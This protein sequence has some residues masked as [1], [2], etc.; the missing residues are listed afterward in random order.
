MP[1]IDNR[2]EKLKGKVKVSKIRTNSGNGITY[3]EYDDKGRFIHSKDPD[4]FEKWQEYHQEQ[5]GG[6][7]HSTLKSSNGDVIYYEY[8]ND[9]N[10]GYKEFPN[11]DRTI[12]SYAGNGK[13]CYEKTLFYNG[14]ESE[15][16]FYEYNDK[17]DCIRSGDLETEYDYD[18]KG[19]CVHSKDSEGRENWYKYDEKGNC[20]YKKFNDGGWYKGDPDELEQWFE[21]DDKGNL[22]RERDNSGVDMQ[23]EYD[24]NGNITHYKDNRGNEEWQEL[25]YYPEVI[26]QYGL[27]D[28]RTDDLDEDKDGKFYMNTATGSVDTYQG[29]YYEGRNGELKNAVDEGK[30]VEVEKD[31]DGNWVEVEDYWK[32]KEKEK[33]ADKISDVLNDMEGKKSSVSKVKNRSCGMEM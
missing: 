18:G 32:Q 26:K 20:V 13:V 25:E 7:I 29:W 31:A 33:I 6:H 22:V 19:N 28:E 17:G 9:G 14:R 1:F 11:G 12:Y 15:V 4:G 3:T 23:F 8:D 2:Q 24:G 5:D 21:Y 30:V 10:V 27:D 16:R